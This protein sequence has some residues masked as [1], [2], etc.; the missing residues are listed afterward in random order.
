MKKFFIFF[1]EGGGAHTLDS[2]W[3]LAWENEKPKPP[4][5]STKAFSKKLSIVS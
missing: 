1:C 4:L 5:F 3:S 2:P